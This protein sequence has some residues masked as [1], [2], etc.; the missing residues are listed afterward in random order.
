M[1]E[2]HKATAD[3]WALVGRMRHCVEFS[4][5]LELLHRIEALEAAQQSLRTDG[6]GKEEKD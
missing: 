1:A 3:D 6:D 2:Q 4:T 5:I